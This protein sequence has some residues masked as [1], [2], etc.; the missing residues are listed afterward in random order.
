MESS[1]SIAEVIQKRY[2]CRSYRE[3]PLRPG[4][5]EA[6]QDEITRL[7]PG[8]L[9]S[10]G[11]FKLAA[12]SGSDSKAL[13]GLGT[14][15]FIHSPQAFLI[16]AS[17][18]SSQNLQDFGYQMEI[19]VLAATQLGLGSC[20]LGGSFT[21]SSFA[22][23]ISARKDEIIPAVCS[24][25]YSISNNR[26]DSDRVGA[27]VD[28]HKR[29]DW[30]KLF[31]MSDFGFP[32]DPVSAAA[33]VFPLEMVRLAPSASNKQ[34][35]RI[36]QEGSCFHFYLQRSKGYRESVLFR[37]LSIV[38]IQQVDMGIAMCHFELACREA[39]LSGEWN[40]HDPGIKVPDNLTEY[41]ITWEAICN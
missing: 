27:R 6:L 21:R 34:P 41:V 17:R 18:N 15:G 20:W 29:F 16:G 11:R 31:F 5:C 9:G 12:A 39:G 33:Y 4:D 38:D 19:L 7:K 25:G 40:F 13:N 24:L 32:L 1:T 3:A 37:I 14:Y 22:Q 2:S 36:I 23:K 35:W 26:P 28:A 30:E 10:S 8:P